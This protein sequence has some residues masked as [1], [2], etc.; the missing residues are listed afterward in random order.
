MKK[1]LFIICSFIVYN[2]SRAQQTGWPILKHYDQD[3]LLN[4]ALPLSGIGTG[5]VSLGGRGEL[6][7]WEIMNKP[8]KGFN[9]V[10]K[11]NN[12]PFFSIYVNPDG[13]SSISRV[14]IGPVHPT[15]FSLY[16]CRPVNQHGFP[17]FARASFDASYPVG[18]VNLSDETMP[19]KVKITGF[20]PL[21]P[22]DADA[23]GLPIAVL[24]YEVTN[25]S[26]KTLEVSVC[27]TMRN[28][29]GIDGSKYIR[30]W[31]GDFIPMG[32][33]NNQNIYRQDENIRG[34]FMYSDSVSKTDAAYGTIALTT[35]DK[36]GV[37]FR[38]SSETNNW[39]RATLDFWDDF[40]TDGELTDK[41]GLYDNDPMASLAVKKKIVPF[42]T[43]VFRF[44]IT[45]N[46]P[47]RYAWSTEVVGNYYCTKYLN[48][49]DAALKIVPRIPELEQRT[50]LFLQ[51]FLSSSLPEVVKESSLFNLSTL[52]SQ[53]V[54]RIKS[55]HMMGWE[56]VMDEF[57][58]C[59]GSCTHVWNYEV[60]TPFLFGELALTMRDVEFNYASDSTGRMCFRAGLPLENACKNKATAADG[61]MGAIMKF[62][63]EWQLS[64]NYDFLKENW[65]RVKNALIF[66]WMKGG[67]DS[68]QDG[69]MEG[70]QHNT[71]DV[72]YFGPN[73]QI[74]FWYFGALRAA[75]E[76]ARPEH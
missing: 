40:S 2:T 6:R 31:K 53:T 54:F 21:I 35:S 44:Y 51:A 37:S 26:D 62:Y 75:I 73:P 71:M 61:Q 47:N 67:W 63:R 74:Q 56:G 38:R 55:G 18:I 34:I 20:N 14:L 70:S 17:R 7:D 1:I 8:A 68:N 43:E 76:M 42:G 72:N 50:R 19:V 52:R 59:Y 32:V 22:G 23:S 33:K 5:T 27:G 13:D 66:A 24:E 15:E 48:A 64:G 11:G 46:F 4:I 69:V 28:F 9:T 36:S 60:A 45:W 29:I 57:G 30:N 10:T 39:E 58:S 3:H 16:E 41:I 65:F 12:A 25:T 49:W